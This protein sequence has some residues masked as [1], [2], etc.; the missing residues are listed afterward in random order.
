MERLADIS[1]FESLTNSFVPVQNGMGKLKKAVLPLVAAGALAG[2]FGGAWQKSGEL[3]DAHD[4]EFS[5]AIESLGDVQ[6]IE[7]LANIINSIDWS[8]LSS[9]DRV[10]LKE[11]LAQKLR[12]IAG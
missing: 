5:T 2:G 8:N 7:G 11:M 12:E 4:K 6:D 9:N 1:K 10:F 3:I